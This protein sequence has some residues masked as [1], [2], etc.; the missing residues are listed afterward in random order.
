[1]R[2]RPLQSPIGLVEGQA[3]VSFRDGSSERPF[4]CHLNRTY[5]QKAV[6]TDPAFSGMDHL[7]GSVPDEIFSKIGKN[8]RPIQS[9]TRLHGMMVACKY[10]CSVL[11]L[12]IGGSPNLLSDLRPEGGV[13]LGSGQWI[14]DDLRAAP[15]V[16]P[17]NQIYAV[18]DPGNHTSVI[19][20]G[21]LQ[22][23]SGCGP[24]IQPADLNGSTR[25]DW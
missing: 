3:V 4:L 5:M 7:V 12:G 6:F 25:R 16:L 1:M 9:W 15:V 11:Y 8:I 24:L 2:V 23:P 10:P 17:P 19:A 13:S 21:I 22:S 18:I 14:I 20:C